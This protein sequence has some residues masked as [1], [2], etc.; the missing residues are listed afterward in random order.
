ME[1]YGKHHHRGALQLAFWTLGGVTSKMEVWD[2]VIEQQ[3]KEDSNPEADCGRKKGKLSHPGDLFHR[4][5]QKAPDGG[6]NHDTG[7]KTG[8]CPR[9]GFVQIFFQEKHAGSPECRSENW[10]EDSVK[11]LHGKLLSWSVD[12]KSLCK[13]E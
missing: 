10:N 6:G 12:E 9:D 11:C 7:C 13:L 2:D 4:R 3:K 5:E 1:R 8:E